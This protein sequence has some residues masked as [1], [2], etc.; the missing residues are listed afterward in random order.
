MIRDNRFE[1]TSH[2]K[3]YT[4]ICKYYIRRVKCHVSPAL[5]YFCYSA[6]FQLSVPFVRKGM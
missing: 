5:C 3:P 1:R 6:P 4:R 2:S